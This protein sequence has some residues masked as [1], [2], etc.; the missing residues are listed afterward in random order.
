M[1]MPILKKSNI[2]DLSSKELLL[3]KMKSKNK[4]EEP[5]YWISSGSDNLNL[6]LTGDINKGYLKGRIV[7]IVGGQ[8][9]GKTALACETINELW[10]NHHLKLK[11]KVKIVYDE[12]ESA[13]D[14]NLAEDFGM[15]LDHIEWEESGTVERFK[16]NIWKHIKAAENY[17]LLLYIVDSL[18]SLSDEKELESQKKEMKTLEKRDAKE[19]GESLEKEDGDNEKDE[20][21]K[22]D[23]GAKKAKELSKFFRTTTRQLRKTNC[24][25]IIISQVR[26]DLRAKYGTKAIRTGGR[27]LD[28]YASQIIWLDEEN[29]LLS[30]THKIPYGT[31]IE[32]YIRKNKLAPPRRR[33]KF[34]LIFNHGVENFGSLIDFCITNG[35]IKKS[36]AWITWG[37]KSYQKSELIKF[38]DKSKE[39]YEKLKEIAQETWNEIEEDVK[40]D[41]NP[42]WKMVEDNIKPKKLKLK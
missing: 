41:L 29:L 40:I 32:A 30:P 17:D 20:K 37:K 8:S 34:N 38:F 21:L 13:F 36:G 15:P 2:K 31:N 25:L 5:K 18:D 1:K 26:D 42:K 23:Y 28:F 4:Q 24:F 6:S 27:G 35:S 10:Y 22:G 11:K 9:T 39:E 33:A 12:N 19:K 3:A 7:N 16:M 14:M